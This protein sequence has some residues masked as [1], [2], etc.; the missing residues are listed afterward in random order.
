MLNILKVF[1]FT[2]DVNERNNFHKSQLI[3]DFFWRFKK[4]AEFFNRLDKFLLFLV[5]WRVLYSYYPFFLSFL[6]EFWFAEFPLWWG[7]LRIL[8]QHLGHYR[9]YG[10]D[11]LPVSAG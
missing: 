2:N 7:G 1:I 5:L 9:G 4:K 6:K 3:S 8:L 10:F 11:P